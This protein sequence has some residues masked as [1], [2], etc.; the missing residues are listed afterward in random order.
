MNCNVIDQQ[1]SECWN[2]H[3][4]TLKH[5]FLAHMRVDW[6]LILHQRPCRLAKPLVLEPSSLAVFRPFLRHLPGQLGTSGLRHA[7][8]FSAEI[9][10]LAEMISHYCYCTDSP[11]E[12]PYFRE[13]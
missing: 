11:A 12:V 5:G 8:S 7:S 13:A 1:E 6:L 9:R 4:H 10:G 2:I 3:F